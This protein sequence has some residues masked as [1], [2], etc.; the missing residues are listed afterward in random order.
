MKL[1]IDHRE[2]PAM[3]TNKLYGRLMYMKVA[4]GFAPALRRG[5]R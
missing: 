1:M 2:W 5:K 3:V 4:L